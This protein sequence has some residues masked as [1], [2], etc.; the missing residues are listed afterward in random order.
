LL[1]VNR[2]D[3]RESRDLED[4]EGNVHPWS[5]HGPGPTRYL[6]ACLIQEDLPSGRRR[7][8]QRV[9]GRGRMLQ[10][11]RR[12]RKRRRIQAHHLEV[13]SSPPHQQEG[14]L[15][16]LSTFAVPCGS[17]RIKPQTQLPRESGF[18]I[19][20]GGRCHSKAA[21]V[22]PGACT[23]CADQRASPVASV[24]HVRPPTAHQVRTACSARA[25]A[26]VRGFGRAKTGRNAGTPV[27]A[28]R[29]PRAWAAGSLE[30]AV[31]SGT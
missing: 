19:D 23:R 11:R 9:Q 29:R 7:R 10:R 13:C 30:H 24:L 4:Q 8:A 27:P 28:L 16:S 12:R 26:A 6:P 1:N 20:V 22:S 2:C 14:G 25:A 15:R 5:Q 3:L 18:I 17:P 31:Q 21:S